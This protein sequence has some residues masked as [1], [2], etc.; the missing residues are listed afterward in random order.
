MQFDFGVPAPPPQPV[1]PAGDSA[2]EL[3]RQ[4]LEVQKETLA[5]QKTMLAAM[6]GNLR[7]RNLLNRWREEFPTLPSMA[8]DSAAHSRKGLRFH[9]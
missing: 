3:L 6:D 7:W 4:L 5:V 9:S 2:A 1:P 8:K